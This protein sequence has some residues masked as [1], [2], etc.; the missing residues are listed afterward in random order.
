[1]KHIS[2]QGKPVRSQTVCHRRD[3]STKH[4]G[5]AILVHR[6]IDHQSLRVPGM[7]HLEKTVIELKLA[8]LFITLPTPDQVSSYRLLERRAPCPYGGS[9]KRLAG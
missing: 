1:M 5:T 2:V 7:W 9:F 3:Q 6:G 8:G 4:G